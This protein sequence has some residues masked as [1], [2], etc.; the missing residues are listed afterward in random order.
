MNND[1]NSGGGGFIGLIIV[2]GIIIF[3]F[4]KLWGLVLMGV[5]TRA[6]R[7]E[8]R[9][10]KVA[11]RLSMMSDFGMQ[12]GTLYAK[13]RDKV[14]HS[15]GYMSKGNVSHYVAVRPRKRYNRSKDGAHGILRV[16]E[17]NTEI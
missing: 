6:E 4:G 9:N 1:N 3:I 16:S 13:H 11:K 2:F 7:R 5:K 15:G 10:K 12:G 17:E 14:Q 8:V